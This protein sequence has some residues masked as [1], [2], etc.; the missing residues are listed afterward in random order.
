MPRYRFSHF[1]TLQS[2]F[3]LKK[4]SSL[5]II[6]CT[7]DYNRINFFHIYSKV[8][9]L[10]MLNTHIF[11][12]RVKNR[13]KQHYYYYYCG[14]TCTLFWLHRLSLLY[15]CCFL[16][17]KCFVYFL[18]HHHHHHKTHTYTNKHCPVVISTWA[19]CVDYADDCYLCLYFIFI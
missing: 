2:L 1:R 15:F 16:L 8:Q 3:Q 13:H 17:F 7:K 6:N 10:N 14:C 12:M 5:K 18:H 19:L 11:I 9:K 4:R